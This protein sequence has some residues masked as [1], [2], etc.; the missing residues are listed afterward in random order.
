MTRLAVGK[1]PAC[2]EAC[3]GEAR[4]LIGD[5]KTVQKEVESGVS[6][7]VPLGV[8]LQ[9]HW[10]S[11]RTR[12]PGEWLLPGMVARVNL[13][14]GSAEPVTLIPREATVDEFGLR[15]VFLV[16]SNGAAS[17]SA[18]RSESCLP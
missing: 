13:E 14:L 4:E 11:I 17:T 9:E 15:F 5:L 6:S 3:P 10:E 16:E 8:R 2:A 18:C 12:T 1:L 7:K